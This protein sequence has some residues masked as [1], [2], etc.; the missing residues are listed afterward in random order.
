M[1][2]QIPYLIDSVVRRAVDLNDVKTAA[3]HDGAAGVAFI[4]G[5]GALP[6]RTIHGFGKKPRHRGLSAAAGPR[7]KIG[8]PDAVRLYGAHHHADSRSL[9]YHFRETLRPVSPVE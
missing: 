1:F 7:K 4:A 3:L 2:F 9:T 5:L 6:L 8:V